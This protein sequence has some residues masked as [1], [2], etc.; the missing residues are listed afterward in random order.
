MCVAIF[1]PLGQRITRKD[2]NDAWDT[3]PDGG[4]FAYR[5][6]V[7]SDITIAKGYMSKKRWIKD[8]L[9]LGAD[10]EMLIHARI[11]THGKKDAD[12][13]HP[14]E[15][16]SGG[17]WIHNG[18][19]SGYPRDH[20]QSD[21]WLF[22]LEFLDTTF[23]DFPGFLTKPYAQKMIGELLAPSKGMFMLPDLPVIIV[24]NH[25][26]TNENGM[27]F[28]NMYFRNRG[29]V[30]TTAYPKA[31]WADPDYHWDYQKRLYVKKPVAVTP[32]KP[33]TEW[34]D[35]AYEQQ[36][37]DH[38]RTEGLL[39]DPIDC[40]TP[41]SQEERKML[42]DLTNDERAQLAIDKQTH[43]AANTQVPLLVWVDGKPMPYEDYKQLTVVQGQH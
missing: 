38:L 11:A 40:T 26:C 31:P 21:T 18:I 20:Q 33:E 32:A 14:F 39:D 34:Y 22:T 28:S 23:T 4:G 29:K 1:K 25:L 12:N 30:S 35:A 37:E 43:Q 9:D 5:E 27:W 6:S 24:N 2:L 15:I 7:N 16:A 41:L 3:N 13:T 17:C 8:I 10:V 19:I 42:A 36:W